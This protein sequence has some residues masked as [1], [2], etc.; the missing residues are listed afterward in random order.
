MKNLLLFVFTILLLSSCSTTKDVSLPGAAPIEIT[1][2]NFQETILD[3]E[4]I[5]VVYF[6]AVWCGPCRSTAPVFKNLA[7]TEIGNTTYGKVNVD[8]SPE[9]ATKYGIRSIPSLLI[10]KNGEVVDRHVG[11]FT[12]ELVGRKVEGALSCE[13]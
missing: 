12:E 2:A 9:I 10:I 5:S 13:L 3:N 7:K 4:N 6:W 1:N 11:T 8:E